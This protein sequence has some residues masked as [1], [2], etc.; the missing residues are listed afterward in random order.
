MDEEL[1]LRQQLRVKQGLFLRMTPF[2]S[3]RSDQIGDESILRNLFKMTAMCWTRSGYRDPQLPHYIWSFWR[4]SAHNAHI[5]DNLSV[6]IPKDWKKNPDICDNIIKACPFCSDFDNKNNKTGNLEHLH[7]YCPSRHLQRVRHYCNTKIEDALHK[8]YDFISYREKNCSRQECIRMC[9][10]Q[11]NLIIAAKEAELEE[12]PTV[13]SSKLVYETR[14]LNQAIRSEH[15]V[16][17]L[18][19]LKKMPPSRIIDFQQ[20]PLCS[21]LGF[22]PAIPEDEFDI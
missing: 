7:L 20:F 14:P 6:S 15:E 11:E 18:V 10:L 3:L 5:I 8:L 9:S 17:N 4:H 21:Q 19:C 16:K 2:H 22:I 1:I 13:Q 12:R